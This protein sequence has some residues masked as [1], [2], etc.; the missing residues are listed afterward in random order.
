MKPAL[1]IA[2]S[3]LIAAVAIWICWISFTQQ[4]A[5]AFVFPRLISVFLVAFSIWTLG[6]ALFGRPGTGEGVSAPVILKLGPGLLVAVIYV[7]WAANALGFYTATAI[8]FFILLT[9]YD[10]APHDEL[11]SWL[12]R[13]AVSAGFMAVMYGL[14]ALLLN[15]YTPREALF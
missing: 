8:A 12:K 2:S 13:L 11:R 3:G 15:V 10:P 6:M 7:F 5:E 4:P 14:F 9:L 1:N